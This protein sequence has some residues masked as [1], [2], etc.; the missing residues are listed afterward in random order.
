MDQELNDA[1]AELLQLTHQLHRLRPSDQDLPTGI[2]AMEMFTLHA[3][4]H[5]LQQA[6]EVR[7]GMVAR[8]M[9]TTNSALSQTLGALEKKGLIVRNR[10]ASDSRAVALGLT[11]QGQR[12]MDEAREYRRRDAANLA[13]YIGLEDLQHV[14]RTLKRVLE[15]RE[16][17]GAVLMQPGEMP[18]PPPGGFPFPPAAAPGNVPGEGEGSPCA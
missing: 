13:A 18:P 15:Y 16:Q 1:Y 8:R 6:D 11:A 17:Q 7:P 12:I 9:H 10:S 2:T 14:C 4:H 5:A 3:I